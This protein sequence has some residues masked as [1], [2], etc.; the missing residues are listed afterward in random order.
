MKLTYQNFP[1]QL[2][3]Q[4]AGFA[5]VYQEHLQDYDEPLPHVLLGDLVRFLSE[6]V[7][8]AG[9]ADP[10]VQTAL[11]LL[12][13]AVTSDDERLQNL[14]V[15]SFLENLDPDDEAARALKGALGPALRAQLKR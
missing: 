15:V 14:V 8:E 6:R 7:Q 4:V 10:A 12:E 1:E 2:S 11:A 9:P 3:Q 13:S 5:A